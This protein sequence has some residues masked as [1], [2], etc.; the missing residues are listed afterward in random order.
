MITF[1]I[2]TTVAAVATDGLVKCSRN[3]V[4]QPDTVVKSIHDKTY[5]VIV[6][7]GGGAGAKAFCEVGRT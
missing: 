1:Q 2:E 4:M 7:P 5:D 6:L 3:V